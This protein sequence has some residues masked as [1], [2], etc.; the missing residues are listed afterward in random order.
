MSWLTELKSWG[1]SWFVKSKAETG[2][3]P[4]KGE[5]HSAEARRKSLTT[6][7]ALAG[8]F[9]NIWGDL[10]PKMRIQNPE[11]TLP[12]HG[13]SEFSRPERE[14]ARKRIEA[15]DAEFM[16]AYQDEALARNQA[17]LCLSGGGIRSAAFALGVIQS[18]AQMGLLTKFH[19]LST[20]SGGGYIGCWLSRLIKEEEDK[21]KQSNGRDGQSPFD[22]AGRVERKLASASLKDMEPVTRLREVSNFLTPKVGPVSTDTWSTAVLSIRNILLNWTVF[23]PL[24]MLVALAPGLFARLADAMGGRTGDASCLFL[25]ILILF[26]LG[27][28]LVG[29]F[30]ACSYLPSHRIGGTRPGEPAR[31]TLM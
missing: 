19:Y 9:M 30:F 24:L 17:A 26:G 4:S 6:S 28:L 8:E 15:R 5:I 18:L 27:V 25:Y 2:K 16:K 21:L 7:E 13:A 22:V 23:V 10:P 20:V 29:E 12:A 3:R 1:K 14:Q 31:R 11:P